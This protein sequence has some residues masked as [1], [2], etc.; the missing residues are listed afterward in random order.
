MPLVAGVHVDLEDALVALF[1]DPPR[2]VAWHGRSRAFRPRAAAAYL[3]YVARNHPFV[4]GSKRRG[5]MCALVFLGL[6]VCRL[7]AGSEALY[8]LVDGVAAGSVDKADVAVFL[9]QNSV[10][11][12][13]ASADGADSQAH[14][15]GTT[16]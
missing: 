16:C 2:C 10:S 6:N 12:Q 3:F 5:L 15:G 13:T 4:D 8:E 1:D 7:D 14:F 11:R 9:R